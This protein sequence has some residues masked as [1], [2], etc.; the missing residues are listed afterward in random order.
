M[1]A[2]GAPPAAA[3]AQRRLFEPPKPSRTRRVLHSILAVIIGATGVLTFA[4]TC[5]SLASAQ[6]VNQP[7]GSGGSDLPDM[8]SPSSAVI[9]KSDEYRLGAQIVRSL[10]DQKAI[11]D[12]PEVAEYLQSL[13]SRLAAQAPDGQRKFTFFPVR[14][15]TI[16]AFALPG[17]FIGVNYGT[18][19]ASRNESELAGVVGHEIAHVTQRHIARTF[20]AQGQQSIAQTAAILAAVL[21][22]AIAGGGDAMQ[23]AIAIAQGAAAQQQVNFT[24]A[25]EY[26]AD[27]VGIGFVAG[28]GFDPNGM[29][30]FFETMSRRTGLAGQYVPEMILTHPVNTNR[31]AEA[32]SRAVQYEHPRSNPDSATYECIRER[33]RVITAPK[34]ADLAARYEKDTQGIKGTLGQ[35]YGLAL[36][37]ME[38]GKHQEAAKILHELVGEHENL[39]LLYSA[40]AQAETQGGL[41][42]DGLAT[43]ARANALFPRNVP[44][45][46]RYAQ[47]LMAAGKAKEAHALLLDVFNN[48]AP[49]PEQIQL[50]ALAASAAG[51]TGDAYYYMSEYHISSGD[52]PLAVQQLELALAAPNLTSVQ[53]QRFQAR[54]DEIR[55]YLSSVRVRKVSRNPDEGGGGR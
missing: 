26:E 54:L 36:A 42:N 49:T 11:L 25:N 50:T 14:E 27:R 45:S 20:R 35:R 10:R 18:V 4:V 48:T 32:R 22:G 55:D 12:D 44:L 47:A 43:F 19:L 51:D 53:R 41:V 29:A 6:G 5:T 31:I 9:T 23:G 2:T 21:I 15:G 3:R 28:A 52:L 33:L 37:L 40:L 46:V 30:T 38:S 34:E 39:T 17:G 1:P 16:N 8:G 13:G 7:G 24:R